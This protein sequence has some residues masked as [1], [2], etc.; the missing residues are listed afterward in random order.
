MSDL[1][2]ISTT[3][4]AKKNS[5]MAK[6]LFLK[7]YNY[8]FI[9]KDEADSWILTQKGSSFGGAYL[10]SKQYGKYIAWPENI[11]LNSFKTEMLNATKLGQYFSLSARKT[12][13]ILSELGWTKKGIKGWLITSQGEKVG[14]LQSEDFKSGIPYVVWPIDIL[15]NKNLIATI[16]DLSG[17]T[18]QENINKED[19]KEEDFREKFEAKH[20]ATDGHFTRSKAEML[21]DNWLYMF[22][23]VHAY[24]RKLPIEENVYCDFYIPAGKVYIE[25][26]GYENDEKYLERK[27]K[28]QEIYKKY[29]L[30]LIELEDAD[31]QN[32]DDVLPKYL[33]KFGVHTF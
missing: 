22:E 26:W 18:K 28:K 25:Y 12:N 13:V 19:N 3:A 2:L 4:L 17:N 32:L 24:E 23:I 16:E 1:K 7:F 20:R 30:N 5:L 11:D 31:I 6:D 29:N 27:K 33:L 15:N 8:G 21:I 9:D 14:G 10:E